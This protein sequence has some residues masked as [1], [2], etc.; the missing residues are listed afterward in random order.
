LA[1]L[2]A[3]VVA[4]ERQHGVLAGILLR[5]ALPSM[6]RDLQRALDALL[7]LLDGLVPVLVETPDLS[8]P[9]GDGG[10]RLTG[11]M[12]LVCAASADHDRNAPRQAIIV[13][14]KKGRLP[15][16]D[17]L[18]P[19]ESGELGR[20]QMPAYAALTLAAGYEP[21]AAYYLSIEGD[22]R[23]K[24]LRCAFGPDKDAAVGP[25]GLS[26]LRDALEKACARAAVILRR[27]EIFV[28][29]PDDQETVCQ[30]CGYRSICRVR[31]EVT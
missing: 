13:D 27:G 9:L 20:Y 3:A 21:L 15:G 5:S 10:T 12:D 30:N 18:R 1:A 8:T 6:R 11:R 2:D 24:R 16:K 17:E 22:A 26:G 4:M 25:E 28:P 23:G 19:G 29:D 31:Y 14:F 7:P